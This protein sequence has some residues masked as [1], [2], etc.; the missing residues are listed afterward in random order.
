VTDYVY[1]MWTIYDH[2][3]DHPGFFVAR[4]WRY[5]ITPPQPT[6]EIILSRTI[7][8]LREKMI[9][10]GLARITRHPTD[11]NVIVETWV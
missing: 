7:E 6:N 11:D 5:D 1:E 10:A 2:P 8:R 3:K 4:K 9:D